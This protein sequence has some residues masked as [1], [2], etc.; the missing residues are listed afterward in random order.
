MNASVTLT[1]NPTE[2]STFGGWSGGGCSGTNP[3]CVVNMSQ[4]QSVTATF[5]PPGAQRLTINKSGEGV[6]TSA[7]SGINCGTVCAFDFPFN[8][9]V[10]LTASGTNSHTFGGWS[11]GGC[12]GTG[13]CTVTMSQA[14]SVTATFTP[15]GTQTLNVNKSGTGT[16]TIISS[17][18]GINCGSDCSENYPFNTSVTLTANPTS[19][20]TFGGWSGPCS[21][22]G[23]CVVTMNQAQSVTATFNP[24]LPQTLTVTTTGDGMVTSQPIGISCDPDCSESFVFNTLVTL[25]AHPDSSSTFAGWSGDGCTGSSLTCQITMDKARNVTATF[26]RRGKQRLTVTKAGSGTGAVTSKPDGINCGGA[27]AFD[28]DFNTPATLTADPDSSSDFAGWSGGGCSGTSLT[29]VVTMDQ[30]QNVTAIFNVKTH[31]LTVTKGGTGTGTVISTPAGINCGVGCR[32]VSFNFPQ[33]TQVTL[34][35][36]PAPGSTFVGWGGDCSGTQSCRVRMDQRRTVTTTFDLLPTPSPGVTP[37]TPQSPGS[38]PP[39]EILQKNVFGSL[40]PPVVL[41]LFPGTPTPPVPRAAL[42]LSISPVNFAPG[43][44]EE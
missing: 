9:S 33:N 7:P 27:C 22:M 34:T 2:P 25:T 31:Q 26:N 37:T 30:P 20:S 32:S 1:A 19:P 16:G 39:G 3:T 43:K 21:G 44:R 42:I 29:C 15:P 41:S 28:F 5:N 24:P 18:A 36:D 10:T 23:S 8:T 40:S 12:S 6:I 14:Q 4:A 38:P 13:T 11:G 35:P 17:P